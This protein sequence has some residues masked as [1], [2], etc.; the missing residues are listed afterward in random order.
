MDAK[1]QMCKRARGSVY[2]AEVNAK[3]NVAV[4]SH[5]FAFVHECARGADAQVDVD[6]KVT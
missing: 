3:R 4:N 1:V 2:I 5:M 6:V